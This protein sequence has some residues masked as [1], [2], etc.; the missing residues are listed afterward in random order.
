MNI[1]RYDDPKSFCD[2]VL[3]LLLQNE[4]ENNLMIGVSLGLAGGSRYSDEPPL[5][6]TIEHQ[7]HVFAA[8]LRTP[9]YNLQLTR[10]DQPQIKFLADS[11]NASNIALPGV[12]GPKETAD[13]FAAYWASGINLRVV[14]E[15]GLGVYQLDQVIPPPQV[16][17]RTEMATPAD[18]DLVEQWIHDFQV[19]IGETREDPHKV[20][21]DTIKTERCWLWKN[22]DPVSMVICSSPTPNG[23][24]ISC[25]YTPQEHRGRGYASANVAALSQRLLDG[26]R[27]F[28]FLFTD[29]ANPTSNSVYQKIGYR[30][31]CDFASVGFEEARS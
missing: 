10:M 9:P 28:C 18:M 20:A 21:S 30:R 26:G 12:I 16:P 15:K 23:I 4:A 2:S 3:P 11:L 13:A 22:P 19:C 25:V 7:G 24:R 27:E 29:L 17:G 14:P 5:M 31:V 8:A 1:T 6:L